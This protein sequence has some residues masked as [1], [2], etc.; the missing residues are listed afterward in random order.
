MY[1]ED[2]YFAARL[3]MLFAR[4]H[5]PGR[6]PHTNAEV[7][8][9]LTASGHPVSK[10]YISQLRSGVRTHPSDETVAALAK[11]FKVRPDYF[12]NDAYAAKIDRDLESR[13]QLE[14]YGLRRLSSR[15]FDLAEGGFGEPRVSTFDVACTREFAAAATE[16]WR[17]WEDPAHLTQWWGPAGCTA[18][19]A[20]IDFRVG[21]T[22]VV[23]LRA[24]AE[25]DGR[26]RYVTMTYRRIEPINLIEFDLACT[27]AAGG[28]APLAAYRTPPRRHLVT[29]TPVASKWTSMTVA[30]FGYPDEQARE[31]ATSRLAQSLD[32]LTAFLEQG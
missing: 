22:S 15:A 18:P 24:P 30:Q 3:N 14:G 10:P 5:L 2:N 23:C 13:A 31:Q 16:V 6:K 28:H 32:R 11:F 8:A 20:D 4:V 21:G 17:A 19:F 12:Y 1:R 26:G 7:A 25:F 9:A 29:L 27:D